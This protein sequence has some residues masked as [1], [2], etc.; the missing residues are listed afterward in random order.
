MTIVGDK[1][2]S[3][4]V[5]A[6]SPITAFY[7]TISNE[8]NT[9]E[10]RHEYGD[11]GAGFLGWEVIKG[12]EIVSEMEYGWDSDE[13]IALRKELGMWYEENEELAEA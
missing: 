12:G 2:S 1:A 5:T 10:F 11:E 9:L 4:Y 7:L 8:Y 3:F 13:G 6:W